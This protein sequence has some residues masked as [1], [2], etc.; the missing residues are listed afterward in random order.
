MFHINKQSLLL[1]KFLLAL[2]NQI[3]LL[4]S[5]KNFGMHKPKIRYN[6]LPNNF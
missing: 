1:V 4:M 6:F 2:N 5:I 3:K